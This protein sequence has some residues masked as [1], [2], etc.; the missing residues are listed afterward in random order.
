MK[1]KSFLAVII[2][3]RILLVISVIFFVIINV[4]GAALGIINSAGKGENWPE[5]F[6]NYGYMLI[7]AAFLLTAG[8]VLCLLRFSRISA[9]LAVSGT[10][11]VLFIMEKI[12]AYADE[13]GFY[14]TLRDMPAS[15]VY[16]QALMPAIA[17]CILI[18]VLSSIQYFS[19]TAKARGRKKSD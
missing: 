4:A 1:N 9:A 7:L 8:A 14:S 17:V 19:F 16:R 18:L 5:Y 10:G 11:V 3:L 6:L 15:S 2:I 12:T 13:A